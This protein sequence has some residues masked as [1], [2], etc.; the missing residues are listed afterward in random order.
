[1]RNS[2]TSQSVGM[3]QFEFDDGQTEERDVARKN[4]SYE[5]LVEIYFTVL[6]V[7]SCMR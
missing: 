2:V 3:T 1:M 4:Q 6:L 7:D 5:L